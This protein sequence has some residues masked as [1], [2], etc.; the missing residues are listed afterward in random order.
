MA[1]RKGS[2]SKKASDHKAVEKQAIETPAEPPLRISDRVLYLLL[3]AAVAGIGVAVVLARHKLKIG[4][5]PEY[6]SACNL[7]G[8][9]NCDKVNT[10]RWSEMFGIPLSIYA[11]PTYAVLAY[12]A[13][14]AL[15]AVR[16]GSRT[17]I[18]RAQLALQS[19]AVIGALTVVYSL[20]LLWVS[21]VW[22]RA[23][24]LYC[25]SLYIIN[26]V[27]TVM[28]FRASQSTVTATVT[29]PLKALVSLRAPVPASIAVML[30][31]GGLSWSV[32]LKA[33]AN[34]EQAYKARIDAQFAK[35]PESSPAQASGSDP[36]A[37]AA[38]PAVVPPATAS[39]APVRRGKKTAEGWSWF[40]T[41]INSD[42]FWFGNPDADVTVVKYADFQCAYCRLLANSFKTVMGKYQDRVRFVM[43][44]FPMN[45]KCNRAMAGFDKHPIACE[46][47]YA[48]H[49]AGEQGKFWE[50]HDLLYD[51]QPSLSL[52]SLDGFATQLELDATRFK[53]CMSSPR[54]EA[55]I[56]SDIETAFRA[57]IYGTPRTYINNRLVT[58]SASASILEYYLEKAL[59]GESGSAPTVALAPVPD[60]TKMIEVKTSSGSTYVDPYECALTKDGR[61]VSMRG[62]EPARVDYFSAKAA[63]EKSGKRLCREEEWVSACTGAPAI[64]N[65][66]NGLFAD[67]T[68]E[69]N[70]YPY[71]P[72][73]E[74]GTCQD[75]ADKSADAPIAT[76]SRSG[77]RTP[78]GVFDLAGNIGE[79]ADSGRD[80]KTLLGGYTTSKSG[81]ACNRRTSTV[82]PGS[83]NITTGFRC[84]AD[85]SVVTST[86]DPGDLQTNLVDLLGQ[87][88]PMFSLTDSGGKS[89]SNAEMKGKVVLINF[90][91]S[92]CGPCKKEFPFLNEYV[93]KFGDRGFQILAIG[94]DTLEQRSLDF[95]KGFNPAFPVASDPQAIMKGKFLVHQMPATFLVDGEGIIRYTATG[96][97][98]EEQESRLREAIEKLL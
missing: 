40:E 51:N 56:K 85:H 41:P 96:F 82:G 43:R 7:G 67:D 60:G 89:F 6:V 61:A 64:D 83:R 34:M 1:K 24:C 55:R 84:C 4:L 77:C 38:R 11:I 90:F 88:V 92:W 95:A 19:S 91:A 18:E 17:G 20:F 74:E 54:T 52:E 63:C 35:A 86:V 79:W 45:I 22:L 49:C 23:F 25:I 68:V 98:G 62:V 44:H 80:R 71:G 59:E 39:A 21:A 97:N 5:D 10:S 36:A 47:A 8:A 48:A 27:V 65:N 12:F 57:G 78:A 9:I 16:E 53:A 13:L 46:A 14:Q 58:G 3:A 26:A 29:A 70:M 81:A 94:V 72:Y 30:V 33:G 50:M 66:N 37:K 73:Y 42:E 87:P 75:N 93:E 28:A 31:A 76:G 32:Y 2:K 15:S 69:G